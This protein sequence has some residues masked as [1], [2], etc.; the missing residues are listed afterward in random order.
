MEELSFEEF[1]AVRR[2]RAAQKTNAQ[3]S[4]QETVKGGHKSLGKDGDNA[5]ADLDAKF[6]D[7]RRMF[8]RL[9]G[10]L[11]S[12]ELQ[13]IMVI[14]I[15]LDLMSGFYQLYASAKG[16]SSPFLDILAYQSGLS[17]ILFALELALVGVA[18][19]GQVLSQA[20]YTLDFVLVGMMFYATVT[21]APSAESGSDAVHAVR[22]LNFFRFWRAYRLFEQALRGQEELQAETRRE[23]ADVQDRVEGFKARCKKAETSYKREVD[24]YRRLE[25]NFRMQRDE[26]ETMKEALQIAAQT[27]AKVQ[28][29]GSLSDIAELM[30]QGDSAELEAAVQEEEARLRQEQKQRAENDSDEDDDEDEGD[31]D[32]EDPI[33]ETADKRAISPPINNDNAAALPHVS[34]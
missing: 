22:L 9:G 27:V 21:N 32:F 3:N 7:G 12:Q 5:D 23:L 29:L 25:Q 15:G 34:T 6:K 31:T 18:F 8:E 2:R 16:W 13:L 19:R 26:L 14:L 10:L 11:Q 1:A 17:L 28:G 20:G 4:E 24:K 33:S 30:E